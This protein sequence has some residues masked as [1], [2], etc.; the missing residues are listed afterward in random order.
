[1]LRPG[2]EDIL[3][4]SSWSKFEG[5]ILARMDLAV[6]MGCDGVEGDQNNPL[7]NNPGFSI[8]LDDEAAW[9]LEMAQQLHARG[10]RAVMKNG[11]EVIDHSTY[12]PQAVRSASSVDAARVAPP[13]VAHHSTQ[14]FP[15]CRPDSW[16][17]NASARASSG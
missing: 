4:K 16:C 14:I 7:G 1:M 9:Y 10:L 13:W 3:P 6:R 5:I 11:V 17:R 15:K 2:E 8:T 12:G